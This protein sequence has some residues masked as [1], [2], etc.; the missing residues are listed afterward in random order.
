MAKLKAC[1]DG[2]GR[3]VK[4]AFVGASRFFR[5]YEQK[6]FHFLWHHMK[7]VIL[8]EDRVAFLNA[9]Q[10]LTAQMDQPNWDLSTVLKTG[11]VTARPV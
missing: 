4:S 5:Q 11:E 6:I 1:F 9:L 3:F 2:K 10:S 8:P 7:D